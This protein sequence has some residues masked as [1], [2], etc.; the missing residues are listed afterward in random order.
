[1]VRADLFEVTCVITRVVI[2]GFE[3]VV[4][5]AQP[6]RPPCEQAGPYLE[7]D[8]LL[9]ELEEEPAGFVGGISLGAPSAF[10]WSA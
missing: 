10:N 2:D 1:V 7:V 5:V 9:G 4:A 3:H 8:E 6:I